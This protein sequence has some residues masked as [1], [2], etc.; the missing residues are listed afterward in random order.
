MYY[1]NCYQDIRMMFWDG[2]DQNNN[3]LS[4]NRDGI[5]YALKRALKDYT[6]R[7]GN[8][9]N[10]NVSASVKNIFSALS[11]EFVNR[12]VTFFQENPKNEKDYDKWHNEM[13]QLFIRCI[14][15]KNIRKKETYGKAQ[16][17]VNMTMKTILCLEGSEEKYNAKY[18]E[19]CHMPLDS[20]TIEWFRSNVRKA[21]E[22]EGVSCAYPHMDV[23]ILNK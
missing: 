18:F 23:T 10:S 14:E 6:P 5:E 19:H 16:K 21:L 20:F 2:K 1:S 9:S 12:F 4:L 22:A 11:Q 15:S 13:C 17:I 8:N 3:L 7:T